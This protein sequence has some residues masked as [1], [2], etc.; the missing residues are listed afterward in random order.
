MWEGAKNEPQAP[1]PTILL[2]CARAR[3]SLRARFRRLR[4]RDAS[5]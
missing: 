2:N 1:L 3:T 5:A 4:S